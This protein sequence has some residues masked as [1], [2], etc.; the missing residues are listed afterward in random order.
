VCDGADRTLDRIG[1]CDHDVSNEYLIFGP[2][3]SGKTSEAARQV[4]RAADKYGAV[5]VLVTS[6]SRAAAAEL[7]DRDLP[8]IADHIGTL[9]SHSWRAL[10]RPRIAEVHADAWNSDN[11]GL[12]IT[13]AS[14][15]RIDGE[16]RAEDSADRAMTGDTLLQQLNRCRGLMLPLEAWSAPVRE[17]AARWQEHKRTHGLLDFCDLIETCLHDLTVAPGSPSVLVADEVQDLNPL[18]SA[19][20]RKWGKRTEYFIRAGDDDQT[21]YSFAGATPESMLDPHIPNGHKAVLKRSHR[22]PVAVYRFSERLIHTVTRRQEK[23]YEPR[24]ERGAVHH[25]CGTYKSPEYS[26]LAS[27][28]RHIA[29][30]RT[31]MFLASCSYMLAP[32]IQV[33]RK[34]AIPFHNPYRRS[35]GFWNPLRLGSRASAA[36]R[37]RAL[38]VS[39]PDRAGELRWTAGELLLWSEWLN[40]AGVVRTGAIELL[41]ALPANRRPDCDLL[42]SLL[43]GDSLTS[44]LAASTAGQ[45]ELLNWWRA[46]I[47][48]DFRGRVGFPADVVAR[49][50]EPA[51]ANPPQVIVGTI[52]SVKGGQ[53]DVVYLF[54]DLSRAGATAYSQSGPLRDS[55]VR[56][57]Y[58]GATRARET[59]Y[60]C[61]P[62]GAEAARL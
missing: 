56:V 54:P 40:P 22:L 16:D 8:I 9:H 58:V 20:I 18:Q 34:H 17:F 30:G 53:A 61:D 11:F 49:R 24:N 35:D 15:A 48:R 3:G 6:F 33:L 26:I 50:G 19:L 14:R 31:V 44:F 25:I 62:A 21:I 39:G 1:Q 2:P 42:V 7:A 52:H 13:P 41:K 23:I 36:N 4:R 45:S 43:D 46:R 51:L 38:L 29:K 57:F 60:I 12:R 27:A 28:E 5:G 10:G 47:G 59:L 32:L 37:L 55:V